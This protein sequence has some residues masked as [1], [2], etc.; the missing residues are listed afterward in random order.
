MLVAT[1][2]LRPP[3]LRI[4]KIGQN[5]TLPRTVAASALIAGGVLAIVSIGIFCSL[6]GYS[7]QSVMYAGVVGA[8]LGVFLVSYSPMKGESLARWLGLKVKTRGKRPRTVRGEHV[9][10]AV[11]ICYIDPPVAGPVQV[12]PGAI[13]VRAGSFDDRGVRLEERR[14]VS[15]GTSNASRWHT[16]VDPS[17]SEASTRPTSPAAA[18]AA[19]RQAAADSSLEGVPVPQVVPPRAIRRHGKWTQDTQEL[20]ELYRAR[21]TGQS[22]Q[23]APSGPEE[24]EAA[25]D[26]IEVEPP[27]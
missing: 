12:K 23:H 14:W 17:S 1:E 10:L 22:Y 9:R 20:S 27:A 6:V 3:K 2:A 7:V 19:Y 26:G 4:G 16:S 25:G 11:G 24:L 18:M 8:A 5:F 21:A 13:P 15:E